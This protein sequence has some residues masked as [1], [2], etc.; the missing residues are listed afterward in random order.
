LV[1]SFA[2][3]SSSQSNDTSSDGKLSN[4]SSMSRELADNQSEEQPTPSDANQ[5]ADN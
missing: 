4:F 1:P 3:I 2:L 5:E